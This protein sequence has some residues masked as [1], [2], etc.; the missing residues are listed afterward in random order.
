VTCGRISRRWG[1]EPIGNM[2]EEFSAFTK[3]E[4]GKWPQIVRRSG[5]KVD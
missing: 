1:A 4:L 3:A 5:A 2:P